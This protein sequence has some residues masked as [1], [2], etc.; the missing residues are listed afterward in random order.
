MAIR[1]VAREV[2]GPEYCHHAVG[3]VP[4][5]GGG[6]GQRAT[7]LTRTFTVAL[8]GDGHLVDHTGHFRGGF[9]QRLA[10]LFTD[11][12][13]QRLCVGLERGGK[14][15][16]H[17]DAC[18]QRLQCPASKGLTRSLDRA[19]DLFGGCPLALPDNFLTNRIQ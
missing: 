10:G 14:S 5:H 12:V 7:L 11:A 9:P 16:E 6:I 2:V 1:Q 3:L 18:L 4:Q 8:Y 15:L 17:T 13:S 19:V